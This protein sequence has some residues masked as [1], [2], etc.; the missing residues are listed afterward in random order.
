MATASPDEN[1]ISISTAI[2]ET[3]ARIDTAVVSAKAKGVYTKEP[4]LVAVSKT[5][6]LS[7]LIAAH[8]LPPSD[9]PPSLQHNE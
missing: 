3:Q 9:P 4:R 8:A 6:P 2:A 7:D 5:K 1:S